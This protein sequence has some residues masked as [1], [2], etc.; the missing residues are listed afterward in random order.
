MNG[1]FHCDNYDFA[2]EVSPCINRFCE[3]NTIATSQADCTSFYPLNGGKYCVWN[4][5]LGCK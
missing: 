5:I 1:T 3:L 2:V 4:G